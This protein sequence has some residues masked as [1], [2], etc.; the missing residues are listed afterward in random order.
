MLKLHA[1]SL[2][3]S[4]K[5]D[6]LDKVLEQLCQ[7]KTHFDRFSPKFGDESDNQGF[8]FEIVTSD[9]D[10]SLL[11]HN[12]DTCTNFKTIPILIFILRQVNNRN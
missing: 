6:D 11:N 8:R 3:Y 9:P 5:Y 7:T 12:H 1:A 2:L 10:K 4:T